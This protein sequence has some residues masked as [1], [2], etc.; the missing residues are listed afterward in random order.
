MNR[1]DRLSSGSGQLRVWGVGGGGSHE[2]KRQAQQRQQ[3]A[4]CVCVCGGAQQNTLS[5]VEKI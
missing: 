4:A 5:W 1:N 2:Q 3:A